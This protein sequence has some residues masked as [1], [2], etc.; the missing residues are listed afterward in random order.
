[1]SG[2]Q[3]A[4]LQRWSNGGDYGVELAVS[5]RHGGVSGGPF[6]SL[7]LGLHVGD[8]VKNV[9]V[10]RQRAAAA[11]GVSLD[12]LIFAEQVHGANVIQVGP[13]ERGRGTVSMD[14]A[15]PACDI[16][17]T[18]SSQPTLVMLVADCV[19]IALIDPGAGVLAVVHAGWRGTAAGAVS[20]GIEAVLNCGGQVHRL[21]AYI[22][23]AVDR[24][25]Y[26]VDQIVVEGLKEAVA[27]DPLGPGV[28]REDGPSHWLVDLVE[29]NRQQLLRSGVALEH[30]FTSGASTADDQYFSDRAQRPC[31]RFALMARLVG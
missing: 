27:P 9:L 4:V 15:I 6:T 2:T 19:P 17:V 18:T 23:P 22:G 26:Q 10:N 25:R 11:F 24:D 5:T 20:R 28:V 14:D 12:S 31:G 1:V 29:A 21:I 13:L 30:I 7:N 16:L 8:D 3:R